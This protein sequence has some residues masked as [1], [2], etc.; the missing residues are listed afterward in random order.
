[1]GKK[2]EDEKSDSESERGGEKYMKAKKRNKKIE[3]TGTS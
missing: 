3:K 1:M 2:N